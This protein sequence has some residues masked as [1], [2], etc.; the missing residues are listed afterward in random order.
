MS[1]SNKQDVNR[2]ERNRGSRLAVGSKPK[3]IT[4]SWV[5]LDK[6]QGQ[7]INSW[8]KEGLLSQLCE[9]MLQVGQYGSA[10]VLAQQMIK[11]YTKVGFP[12]HSKF[13]EPTHITP[14]YWAVIHIKPSSK[15]VVAGYLE[16]DV[17]YIVF[18]DKEH[19]FW[20]VKDI[21]DR[22]KTKR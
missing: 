6:N 2:Y 14:S 1:K 20:P 15:S 7:T 9:M 17:F 3:T 8:E 16:E 19:D 18:L 5:K 12:E 21:Q 11:Q 13:K 22:G 10:D 4:F